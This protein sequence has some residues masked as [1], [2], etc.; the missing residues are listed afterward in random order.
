MLEQLILERYFEE[1]R[2]WLARREQEPAAWRRAGQGSDYLLY[3]TAAET[4]R[5]TE[6]IDAM[7]EEFV[8]RN[9]DPAMRPKGS[10]AVRLVHLTF[11]STLDRHPEQAR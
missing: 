9:S 6:R 3:L 2:A 10:R 11:P 5:L 7:T 8:G 4:L 1:A